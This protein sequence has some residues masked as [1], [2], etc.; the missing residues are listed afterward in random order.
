MAEQ[1]TDIAHKDDYLDESGWTSLEP[2]HAGHISG[3]WSA[4]EKAAPESKPHDHSEGNM[5]GSRN[6]E[7]GMKPVEGD[8]DGAPIDPEADI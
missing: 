8:G 4:V 2:E 1:K 5:S 7:R 6:L 3:P